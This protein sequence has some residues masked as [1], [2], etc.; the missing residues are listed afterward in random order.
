MKGSRNSTQRSSRKTCTLVHIP[1]RELVEKDV[2]LKRLRDQYATV[3]AEERRR[4]A[5]WAY[6]SAHAETLMAQAIHERSGYHLAWH[7]ATAPLAIDPDYAPAMLS[8]ASLDTLARCP[9]T[10]AIVPTSSDSAAVSS[11]WASVPPTA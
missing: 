2:Q 4:A 6:D 10:A 5:Q 1:F 11:V 7:D 8:V 9:S 3:T